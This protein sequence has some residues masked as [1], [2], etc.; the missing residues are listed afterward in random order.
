MNWIKAT[1]KPVI[2]F[3]IIRIVWL[4][5]TCFHPGDMKE[6][7]FSQPE[8]IK[9]CLRA[10]FLEGHIGV[11]QYGNKVLRLSAEVVVKYGVGVT[12][13]EAANQEKACEL[14]DPKVV[15]VPK[16]STFFED[17]SWSRLSGHGIQG[18]RSSL[19]GV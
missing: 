7:K 12:K 1:F 17:D 6:L 13:D 8:I 19:A 5:Y 16:V 10:A 18:R 4:G 11:Q 2:L 9:R 15:R 14:L 3:N